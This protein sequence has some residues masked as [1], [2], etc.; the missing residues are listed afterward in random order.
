MDQARERS[1]ARRRQNEEFLERF[2]ARRPDAAA[3]HD[4]T[5]AEDEARRSMPRAIIAIHGEGVPVDETRVREEL[6][7]E[8][9]VRKERPVLFIQDD[10]INTTEVTELGEEAKDLV[11]QPRAAQERS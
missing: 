8:T 3:A 7:L 10:W 1:S 2:K 5:A 11:K 6:V 9:L 4:R